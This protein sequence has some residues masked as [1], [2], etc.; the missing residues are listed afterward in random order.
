[1]FESV[2]EGFWS[3]KWGCIGPK[4]G[5]RGVSKAKK[6]Q[7]ESSEAMD[8]GVGGMVTHLWRLGEKPVFRKTGARA[9]AGVQFENI[10]KTRAVRKG[11]FKG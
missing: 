11:E 7:R 1:M 8:R 10:A 6:I 2:L 4:R 3:S 9:A 5:S